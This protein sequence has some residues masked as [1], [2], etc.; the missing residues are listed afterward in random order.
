M[1][2]YN[3]QSGK[4]IK[5][6]FILSL[7]PWILILTVTIIIFVG[8]SDLSTIYNP[9]IEGSDNKID[10]NAVFWS[11]LPFA[12]IASSILFVSYEVSKIFIKNIIQIKK[13]NQAL[14]KINIIANDVADKSILDLDIPENDKFELRTKLKMDLLREHLKNEVGEEYE[15]KLR[16][17]LWDYL[18]PRKKVKKQTA[19]ENQSVEIKEDDE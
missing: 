3:K 14:T 1:K 2:E 12:I 13:Q 7:I 15:Y 5:L 19:T 17:S 16:T 8:T 6:Y 4:D 11:R 9:N 18:K 10:I